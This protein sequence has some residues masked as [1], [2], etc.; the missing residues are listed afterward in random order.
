VSD[1]YDDEVK[2]PNCGLETYSPKL[3]AANRRIQILTALRVDELGIIDQQQARIQVLAEALERI[4]NTS[5]RNPGS[6]RLAAEVVL[7]ASKQDTKEGTPARSPEA[8]ARVRADALKEV[9]DT[10]MS[11]EDYARVRLLLATPPQNTK[12]DEWAAE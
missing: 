5:L 7:A 2:C 6:M 10:R 8:D 9:L 1:D 4:R 12:E 3:D 11:G